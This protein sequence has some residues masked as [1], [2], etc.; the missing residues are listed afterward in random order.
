M[1]GNWREE[2]ERGHRLPEALWLKPKQKLGFVI[3][4]SILMHANW[5]QMFEF[6]Q[7]TT[8]TQCLRLPESR[9]ADSLTVEYLPTPGSQSSL[10]NTD[11]E[12]NSRVRLGF[13]WREGRALDNNHDVGVTSRE[14]MA[15]EP[16]PPG[17]PVTAQGVPPIIG[18]RCYWCSLRPAGSNS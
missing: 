6:L 12:R 13:G 1:D 17:L 9:G 14:P 11:S 3:I 7:Q 15:E 10:D 16:E 4:K 8:E 18:S 2:S 5:F